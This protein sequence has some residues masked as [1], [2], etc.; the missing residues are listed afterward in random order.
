M[1]NQ[2]YQCQRSR[3][4]FAL[5]AALWLLVA[6]AAIGTAISVQA[7][8]RRLSAANSLDADRGRAAAEA[9]LEHARSRLARL[10]IG[11]SLPPQQIAPTVVDPWCNASLVLTDTI[12]LG[13]ERYYVLVHDAGATLNLNLASEEELQ[14]FLAALP[15]DAGKASD[16]AQSVMDWRDTDDMHRLHGAEVDDYLRNGSAVL[17]A[18][19]GFSRVEELQNV[20][21]MTPQIFARV[22][23]FLTLLGTGQINLNSAPR[24]VL[25]ALP[26]MTD[27][28]VGVLQRFRASPT[29]IR[30][31]Q[32][33]S[34]QLS[35]GPR[36]V[37]TA[38]IPELLPLVSFDTREL[39]V[40]SEGWNEDSP[41]HKSIDALIVRA[42]RLGVVSFRK[43]P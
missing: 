28:A 37:L 31:L 6:F 8:T 42:G 17:P 26:G 7:K 12:E 22:R 16:I 34:L 35:S 30:S 36:A 23:P 13:S 24:P 43:E 19:G 5:I 39:E 9:G 18:N 29:S 41:V 40:R 33:L 2:F 21:G 20:N 15:I 10:L 3:R 11:T 38:A 1:H 14:R 25:L 4:G 27:E 32:E